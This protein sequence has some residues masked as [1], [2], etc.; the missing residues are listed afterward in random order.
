V[1]SLISLVIFSQPALSEV[2]AALPTFTTVGIA[3]ALSSVF[4]DRFSA[5]LSSP[6]LRVTSSRDIEQALG[7]ERQKQLL[8]CSQGESCLAELAGALGVEVIISGSLAKS[9][10]GYIC[11]LRAIRASDGQLVSSLSHRAKTEDE[12]LD[13]LDSSA[14]KVRNEI[15]S[16]YGLNAKSAG[17]EENSAHSLSSWIPGIAGAVA[18]GFGIGGVVYGKTQFEKFDKG[19]PKLLVPDDIR[20]A[21]R[22]ETGA[23]ILGGVGVAAIGASVIWK[24][25][26]NDSAP[27]ARAQISVGPN[28]SSLILSGEF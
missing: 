26:A 10:S 21:Q 16:A 13:F 23:F 19:D 1:I 24:L 11:S 14:P 17:T 4:Q 7:L 9:E 6:Q 8:G 22:I 3:E 18:L 27:K 12:L 2:K 20:T 5:N 28:G 15:L 25:L